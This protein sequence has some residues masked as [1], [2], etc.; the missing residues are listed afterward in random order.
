MPAE[1]NGSTTLGQRSADSL[2]A[3]QFD[4]VRVE[5]ESLESAARAAVLADL[6]QRIREAVNNSGT[7]L[8]A[9]K[10]LSWSDLAILRIRVLERTSEN[11]L[12]ARAPEIRAELQS[13]VGE[14][15]FKRLRPNG[16]VDERTADPKLLLADL[17]Q[18]VDLTAQLAGQ[19]LNND[20]FRRGIAKWLLERASWAACAAL[21]LAT[22][23][24]A[25]SGPCGWLVKHLQT[26]GTGLAAVA[27]GVT[28]AYVSAQRRILPPDMQSSSVSSWFALRRFYDTT[29]YTLVLG[30]VFALLWWLM[31]VGGIVE[32]SLFPKFESGAVPVDIKSWALFLVWS[33][34]SGFAERLVLDTFERLTNTKAP[35]PPLAPAAKLP[36][37]NA[38][39]ATKKEP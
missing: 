14:E 4:A 11:M 29:K 7:Q 12:R 22:V 2:L 3:I 20:L 9:G 30:G 38:A 37:P 5:F 36:D 31:M 25:W 34:A 35:P 28:G 13:L 39:A 26:L 8:D 1:A 32:G 6:P 15:G 24:L 21:V 16:A 18:M 23:V 27:F 17:I 33:F 19:A 10:D